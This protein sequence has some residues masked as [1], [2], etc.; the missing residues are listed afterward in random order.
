ATAAYVRAVGVML[1]GSPLVLLLYGGLLYLTWHV[2][3]GTPT[4]FI[5]PQD[6]GY[7]LV[8]VQLPD[9]ASLGRTE[10]AIRRGEEAAGATP[11][12]QPPAAV[13]GQS[14]LLTANALNFGSMYVMLDDSHDRESPE[15]TGDAIAERLREALAS[16][17][18]EAVVNVFGAPPVEGLGT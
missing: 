12:V 5:P 11:G 4:G 10:D 6:K 8:N 17:V 3:T 9:S 14:L 2:F 1:F 13:A 16:E 15:L 7:L 18:P